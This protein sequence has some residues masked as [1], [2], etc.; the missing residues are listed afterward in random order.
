MQSMQLKKTRHLKRSFLSRLGWR[1]FSISTLA[2]ATFAV[3][4]GLAQQPI[5]AGLYTYYQLIN[6]NK[7][8]NWSV[9]GQT[10]SGSGCLGGGRLGPFGKIGAMLEGDPTTNS[11]TQTVTR[12]I[13]ILDIASGKTQTGVDLYIYQKNDVISSGNDHVTVVLS[14]VLSLPLLGG[15]TSFASMAANADYLVIGTNRSSQAIE[16]VKSTLAMTQIGGF[17]P[18]INVHAV[19]ADAYGFITIEF[20]K[21]GGR[22]TGYIT[23]GP[24]GSGG[25]DGGSTQLMLNT[26]QA[27]LP[28]SLK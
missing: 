15:G 22:D 4:D 24:D 20:G 5:D 17:S 2:L 26:I 16:V 25:G 12:A 28:Q 18:P 9:C 14:S 6:S 8:V 21:I 10:Q 7:E 23:L 11:S 27:I 19:T 1:R 3:H 13:Y